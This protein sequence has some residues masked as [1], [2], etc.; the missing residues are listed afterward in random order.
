[1]ALSAQ[2]LNYNSISAEAFDIDGTFLDTVP[3]PAGGQAST[4]FDQSTGKWAAPTSS[5]NVGNYFQQF[6]V[7]WHRP[8]VFK[9]LNLSISGQSHFGIRI[10][11]LNMRYQITGY[12][13]PQPPGIVTWAG[14]ASP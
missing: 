11:N 12:P 9:Q 2:F 1:M 14:P 8:L 3:L 5:Q 7:Y 13:L 10:A 6:P 4:Y